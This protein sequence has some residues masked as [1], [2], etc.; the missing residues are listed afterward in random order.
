[1]G[2]PSQLR[3]LAMSNSTTLASAV[4]LLGFL[5]I[6]LPSIGHGFIKD[7]FAWI[8]SSA[9]H[10]PD[11][12]LRFFREATGFFRPLVALTFAAN[13][14]LWDLNPFWY[15]FVNLVLAISCGIATFFLARALTLPA[16]AAVCAAAIWLFN[17]HGI[18]MAVLWISGRTSLLLT[19]FSVL[20]AVAVLRGRPLAAGLLTFCA[21][22]SKEEAVVLPLVLTIWVLVLVARPTLR[23][24]VVRLTPCWLAL[25]VYVI[26]RSR[27]GAFTPKTAPSFY[28]LSF[29]PGQLLQNIVQYADRAC[30]WPALL[31]AVLLLI[32]RR[33]P[34]I[35]KNGR[36]ILLGFVWLIAGFSL[37]GFLPVRS[38]LYA[39]FPSVGSALAAATVLAAAWTDVPTRLRPRVIAAALA[40]PFLLWPAYHARTQRWVRPADLSAQVLVDLEPWIRRTRPDQAII[41]RDNRTD[42]INLANAF[43]TLLPEAVLLRFGRPVRAWIEPAVPEADVAGMTPPSAASVAVVLQLRYGRLVAGQ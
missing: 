37:T 38:S 20:A 10:R 39:C 4:L 5:A 27:T 13:Y 29:E 42:R 36:V 43:G 6:Y 34:G 3:R 22:L 7:D 16:P 17:F 11:D 9:V 21:L 14:A 31:I 30:T 18:N 41:L 28:R 26:L 23:N 24:A 8:L 25:G 15:G 40:L 32:S 33:V 35:D 1:M 19:V 2:S 12:L